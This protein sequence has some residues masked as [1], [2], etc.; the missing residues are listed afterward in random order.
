MKL[1]GQPLLPKRAI[2]CCIKLF[3][4][5][6]LYFFSTLSI[7][8]IVDLHGKFSKGFTVL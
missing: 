2:H 6:V 5:P 4:W 1:L 8:L 7:K 3:A